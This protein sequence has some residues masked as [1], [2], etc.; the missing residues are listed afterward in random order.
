MNGDLIKD[1]PAHKMILP[2]LET[3]ASA[4]VKGVQF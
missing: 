1:S 4:D 2:R 3:V